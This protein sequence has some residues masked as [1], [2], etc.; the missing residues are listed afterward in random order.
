MKRAKDKKVKK[1]IKVYKDDKGKFIRLKK[2][3]IRVPPD[4]TE[5]Q[6]LKFV[7]STLKPKRRKSKKESDETVGPYGKIKKIDPITWS[8]SQLVSKKNDDLEQ[9]RKELRT[10]R[11]DVTSQQA[12]IVPVA[13]LP[14]TDGK[15]KEKEKLAIKDSKKESKSS[16]RIPFGDKED[17]EEKE[18]LSGNLTAINAFRI[19][20]V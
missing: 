11:N 20:A 3:K 12:L 13:K 19:V 17:N 16:E 18:L 14:I 1:K 7:I 2:K 4:I 9:Q 6:L 5:R 8:V 10:L 15:E